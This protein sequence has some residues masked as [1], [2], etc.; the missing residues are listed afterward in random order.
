MSAKDTKFHGRQR[1]L[2]LIIIAMGT[3]SELV[4]R[5]GVP[6]PMGKMKMVTLVQEVNHFIGEAPCA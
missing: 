6:V 4:P 2:L 1:T 5:S 3:V